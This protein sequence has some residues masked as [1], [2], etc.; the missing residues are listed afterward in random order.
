MPECIA[1]KGEY[2]PGFPCPRC[3]ADTERWENWQL[4]PEEQGGVEGLLA[5]TEP[6]LYLPFWIILLAVATGLLLLGSAVWEGLEPSIQVLLF[7]LTVVGCFLAFQGT[8]ERRHQVRVRNLLVQVQSG[9]RARL[10][11]PLTQAVVAPALTLLLVFL[12]LAGTVSSPI[13]RKLL[14]IFF[15]EEGYCKD[16]PPEGLREK[17]SESF[18]LLSAL[19]YTGFMVSFTFSST[20]MLAIRYARRMDRSLPMPVFLDDKRLA[21]IVRQ[22]AIHQLDRFQGMA[23]RVTG[24]AGVA[25]ELDWGQYQPSPTHAHSPG[26]GYP[27]AHGQTLQQRARWGERYQYLGRWNWEELERTPDGGIRMRAC[28]EVEETQET[29]DGMQ[30]KRWVTVVY[31]VTADPWGRIRRIR[32]EI[33]TAPS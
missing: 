31:T 33:Q 17:L 4:R 5:F 22:T 20:L 26:A 12:M 25:G 7:A 32:R 11:R 18:P 27:L 6:H 1:C 29:M 16:P 30:K 10:G 21:R 24:I 28:A 23:V 14:C 2:Q 19:S 9:W 15:F 13:L 8:Y 3:G